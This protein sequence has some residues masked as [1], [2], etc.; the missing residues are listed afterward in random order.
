MPNLN[1]GIELKK[2]RKPYPQTRK[3]IIFQFGPGRITT[4]AKGWNPIQERN[5]ILNHQF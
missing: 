3:V 4:P 2:R 1:L 5:L